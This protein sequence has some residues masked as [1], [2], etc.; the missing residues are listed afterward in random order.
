M[1]NDN[2]QEAVCMGSCSRP[3]NSLQNNWLMYQWE[4]FPLHVK[5]FYQMQYLHPSPF[6]NAFQ[7]YVPDTSFPDPQYWN[8]MTYITVVVILIM[9][10][11]NPKKQSSKLCIG[12]KPFTAR[13]ILQ[14]V[15]MMLQGELGEFARFWSSSSEVYILLGY[16]QHW[17]Y[18]ARYFE[19]MQWSLR[20]S[21]VQWR[22]WTSECW[23]RRHCL[24]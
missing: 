24:G 19:T 1:F 23:R 15:C 21:D 16:A 20:Q 13:Y 2:V 18:D 8:S 22:H 5:P 10:Y 12:N 4:S 14:I 3:R 11:I 9:L 7:L 17:M 6:F